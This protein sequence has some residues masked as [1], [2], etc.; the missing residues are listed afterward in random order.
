MPE[1]PKEQPIA[2]MFPDMRMSM[3]DDGE[4]MITAP[5]PEEP[6]LPEESAL[7]DAQ[8]DPLAQAQAELAVMKQQYA[9]AQRA[10]AE[11]NNYYQRNS[12]MQQPSSQPPQPDDPAMAD[13]F[14][15]AGGKEKL[16]EWVQRQAAAIVL[17][18]AQQFQ[19]AMQQ[20]QQAMGG[21]QQQ[22][23]RQELEAAAAK[24]PDLVS[25][26]QKNVARVQAL[27]QAGDNFE[28]IYQFLN[29]SA[30]R[31]Q[32][33][34]RTVSAADIPALAEKA[35][36]LQTERGAAPPDERPPRIG[37]VDDAVNMA[38]RQMHTKRRA[39]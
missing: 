32:K 23:A 22:T 17:P 35:R 24:Y 34:K 18:V 14:A 38:L 15:A 31:T 26:F 20:Q 11:W 10:N 19:Q 13:F 28:Q 39:G 25:V 2:D 27:R 3:G 5:E 6:E 30:V 21:F 36:R 7:P 33:A 8:P 4:Y 16:A 9:D 37:S 1:D 12:S 29:P